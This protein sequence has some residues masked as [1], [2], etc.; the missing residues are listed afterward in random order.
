MSY[1]ATVSFGIRIG[2]GSN[3][4]SAIYYLMIFEQGTQACSSVPTFL[5]YNMRLMILLLRVCEFIYL[6][7]HLSVYPSMQHFNKYL[8]SPHCARPHFSG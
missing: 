5:T 3:Y 7:I 2:L 6:F 8:L 4:G 1:S